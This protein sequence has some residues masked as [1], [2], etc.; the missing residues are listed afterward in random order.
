[1][2]D[3][4]IE[5]DAFGFSVKDF[6][7]RH[8]L[9]RCDNSGDLY[10][11]TK[12]SNLPTAFVSTSSSTWHQRLSHL[13]DEV[14]CSLAT[15]H[16][17]SCNKEKSTHVCHACQFGKH[18]KLIFHS[19][20]SS[21]KNCFDIIHSDLWTSPFGSETKEGLCKEL[22]FSLVDN[23]KLN[24]VYLINR[25]FKRLFH[26]EKVYKARKRFHYVK[27]NKA[28]SLGKRTSKVGI[29]AQQLSLKDYTCRDDEE[30]T[31]SSHEYLNDL[32]EE[33][34]ARDL[35]AKSKRFFKKEVSSNENES[36]EVKALMALANE[37]RVY[38]SKKSASNDEYVKISI[39][40]VHTLLEMED[41][42]DRNVTPPN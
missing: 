9:I 2:N 37:E 8:I 5:F 24:V 41:N 36:I 31:R 12:P 28:I 14:L 11:V 25:R 30:D 6:L 22:Q 32:E 21:V 20:N 29:E 10:P 40:K 1:D 17:I 26:F 27:R 39:Q 16:L 38:V 13:G 15:H 33:Y 42:D 4:T 35:L 19:L 23:S 34:Q 18:E 7:T 3:C